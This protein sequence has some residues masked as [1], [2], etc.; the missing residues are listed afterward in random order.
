MAT[1]LLTTPLN[2]TVGVAVIDAAGW[3]YPAGKIRDVDTLI[4]VD[5]P[6][7]KRGAIRHMAKKRFKEVWSRFRKAEKG[8]QA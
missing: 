8:I 1:V 5:M 6:N 2:V 7:K 4:V 3:V